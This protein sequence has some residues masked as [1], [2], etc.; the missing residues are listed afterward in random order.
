MQ[1]FF[2]WKEG[3]ITRALVCFTDIAGFARTAKSLSLVQIAALLKRVSSIISEHVSQRP[4]QVVKYLGDASLLVFPEEDVDGTIWEL[5]S[6]KREIEGYFEARYPDLSITFSAHV[7]KVIV[8]RLEPITDLDILGETVNRASLLGNRARGG[9]FV[10]SRDVHER[11][12]DTTRRQFR[13]AEVEVAY[14]AL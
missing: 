8:V 14:V 10:I 3:E 9:G 5:L 13:A 1:D 12:S 6:M 7:G 2:G 4:G 11:L